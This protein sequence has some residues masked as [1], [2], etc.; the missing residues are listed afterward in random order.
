MQEHLN[1][2]LDWIK[3][4]FRYVWGVILILIGYIWK[5]QRDQIASVAKKVDEHKENDH[6]QHKNFVT[7][8]YLDR[9]LKPWVGDIGNRVDKSL[10]KLE[11]KIDK[12]VD[13]TANVIKREEY[14]ADLNRLYQAIDRKA[15][16]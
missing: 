11:R 16:R 1:T 12:V 4:A 7:Y 10:D 14:K 13:Q 15:D 9:E 3:D 2:D 5:S 8:D 6:A